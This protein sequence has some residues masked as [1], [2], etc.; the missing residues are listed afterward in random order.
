M[1]TQ[2]KPWRVCQAG[3][4][5]IRC[6]TLEEARKLATAKSMQTVNEQSPLR[7]ELQRTATVWEDQDSHGPTS[8]KLI[9][10]FI[11]GREAGVKRARSAA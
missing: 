6:A 2:G 11:S 9:A 4:I 1:N 3:Q 10:T 7:A 8:A 5:A